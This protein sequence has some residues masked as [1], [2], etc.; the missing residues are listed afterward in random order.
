MRERIRSMVAVSV[1]L[2]GD[3]GGLFTEVRG[4]GILRSWKGLLARVRGP[5]RVVA[6][7]LVTVIRSRG[8]GL[9]LCQQREMLLLAAPYRMTTCSQVLA[10][11]TVA[12]TTH[13]SKPGPPMAPSRASP[14]LTWSTSLPVPPLAVSVS[15]V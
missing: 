8:S 14:S 4:R 7:A 6:P 1:D 9:P 11:S 15:L 13:L 12:S 5:G 10:A 3:H 2:C